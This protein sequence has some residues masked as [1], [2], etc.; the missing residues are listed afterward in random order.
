M[1]KFTVLISVVFVLGLFFTACTTPPTNEMDKA[2]D[3]VT[4]AENDADAVAYA[5][6]TLIRAREALTRM[7]KEAEAKRYDAA[8]NY[9]AEAINYAEK[10]IADGKTG[11][12]RTRDEAASLIN[13]LQGSLEETT[14]ALDA[15]RGVPNIQLDFD[16]LS[17][18]LAFANRTYEDARQS[19]RANNYLDA[20]ARAQA[21]RSI[22]SGINTRINE[23]AQTISRKK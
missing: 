22:L 21:V 17:R 14:K 4:R 18:D 15:A 20:I 5:P 11:L 7:Q 3:A 19:F 1:K 2:T 12:A 6:D 8:K 9:A 13:S 16:A 23:A 10:A